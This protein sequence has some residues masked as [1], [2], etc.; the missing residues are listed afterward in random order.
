[1]EEFARTFA[2]NRELLLP[3]ERPAAE[4]AILD[5][6]RNGVCEYLQQQDHRN[7]PGLGMNY[8]NAVLGCY[9]ALREANFAV[10]FVSEEEIAN[11][12][13]P[14]YR[15]LYL[16]GTVLLTPETGTR[17]AE[18]VRQGARSGRMAAA[19]G[20]TSICSSGRRFP[21]RACSGYSAS[22]SGTTGR[23]RK[24]SGRKPLPV[25]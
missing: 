16:P 7:V 20:L 21:A 4:I 25:P 9:R 5:S 15:A 18:F 22:A 13:L 6:Y 10:E 12:I 19:A 24:R 14:R 1:M 17:I 2:R 11:G 8:C 3:A 23:N